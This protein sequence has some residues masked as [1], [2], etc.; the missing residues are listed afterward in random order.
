MERRRRDLPP[1]RRDPACR[2]SWLRRGAHA[3][4]RGHRAAIA[5]SRRRGDRRVDRGRLERHATVRAAIDWSWSLLSERRAGGVRSSRRV[6]RAIRSRRRRA[7]DRRRDARRPGRR[8]V[9]TGRQ[10]DGGHRTGRWLRSVSSSPCVSTGWSSS[11]REAQSK[12]TAVGHAE[13]YATLVESLAARLESSDELDAGRRLDDARRRTCELRLPS[14][15]RVRTSD[16][17]LPHR[18]RPL[19][20]TPNQRVWTE[21]WG[22]SDVAL[23]S[24][25][26]DVHPLRH[27]ADDLIA[28][29]GA[30][31][32]GDQERARRSR[33]RRSRLVE[34]GSEEWRDAAGAS[35]ADALVFLGRF[36]ESRR[37]GDRRRRR[38]AA[39]IDIL[40]AIVRRMVTTG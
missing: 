28:G 40:R 12:A 16:L 36:E 2:S 20:S 17:V 27:G 3:L 29:Q 10:V 14:L 6:R 15:R 23:G 37:S 33:T 8:H 38:P 19:P 25:G 11:D 5:R 31:Q 30:W 9:R 1:A 34:E 35:R 39:Y 26:A 24:P 4:A 7:A 21:A 22:W 13:H 32:L 18:R